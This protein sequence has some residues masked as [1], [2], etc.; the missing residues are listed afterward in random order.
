MTGIKK[1][2]KKGTETGSEPAERHY[3]PDGS[4]HAVAVA[5]RRAD[6]RW[7]LIRRSR[8]V[9]AARRVAFPGGALEAGEDQ[10]AAAVREM[11]EELGA[12]VEPLECVW[13][14]A[15]PDRPM[16]LWGWRARLAAGALAPDPREVEEVLWLSAEEAIRHPD[17]TPQ[18]PDFLAALERHV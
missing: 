4:V 3:Q 18:L 11:G 17:R 7:L 1:G 9:R 16:I 10:A 2:T 8:H 15:F 12:R 13:R 5:C 14:F 6:G